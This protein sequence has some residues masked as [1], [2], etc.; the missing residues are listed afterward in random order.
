[1]IA[2]VSE[3][4]RALQTR[5]D[6]TRCRR[7]ERAHVKIKAAR[8]AATGTRM[9]VLALKAPRRECARSSRAPW[10]ASRRDAR[11]A[12]RSPARRRRAPAARAGPAPARL[13]IERRRQA[14]PQHLRQIVIEPHRRAQH[15]GI[16]G[17]QQRRAATPC[18]ARA[19]STCRG[20][21]DARRRAR[22]ADIAR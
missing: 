21:R 8:F 11:R 16:L 2:C 5:D 17:R 4:W 9:P 22:A 15:L 1:M 18:R 10:P 3:S 20:C 7:S 13:R 19:R 12:S 14:Q 6:A